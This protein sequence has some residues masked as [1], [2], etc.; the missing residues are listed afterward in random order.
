[1]NAAPTLVQRLLREEDGSMV[2]EAAFLFCL[3]AAA[4]AG[5]FA[6][7][8]SQFRDTFQGSYQLK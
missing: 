4:G 1:M 8:A 3:L 7:T 6:F 2:A 5:F